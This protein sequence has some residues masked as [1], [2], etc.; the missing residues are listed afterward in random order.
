MKLSFVRYKGTVIALSIEDNTLQ[1]TTTSLFLPAFSSSK[2]I[3][4]NC[5]SGFVSGV[6]VLIGT[7]DVAIV[8][9]ISATFFGFNPPFLLINEAVLMTNCLMLSAANFAPSVGSIWCAVV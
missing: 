4:F 1:L 7:K 3:V 2:A 6:S 9:V 5:F 8:F